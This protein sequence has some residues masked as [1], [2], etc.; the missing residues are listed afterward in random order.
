M[1]VLLFHIAEYG[2]SLKEDSEVYSAK[3]SKYLGQKLSPEKLPEHF[4]KVKADII[5]SFEKKDG[6]KA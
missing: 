1:L 6:K 4:G 5:K 3:F 2:K